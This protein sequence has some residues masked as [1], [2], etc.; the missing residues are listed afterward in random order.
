MLCTQVNPFPLSLSQR[1]KFFWISLKRCIICILRIDIFPSHWDDSLLSRY[2]NFMKL[3]PDKR[4]DYSIFLECTSSWSKTDWTFAW[5]RNLKCDFTFVKIVQRH[6]TYFTQELKILYKNGVIPNNS[7]LN[8][9]TPI[10]EAQGL[11]RVGGRL[12]NSDLFYEA[13]HQILLPQEKLFFQ[14]I[15]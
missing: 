11:I 15:D 5:N 3:K 2:S 4:S 1:E 8:T 7:S 9:L 6:V 13:R 10:L 14:L 12:Q